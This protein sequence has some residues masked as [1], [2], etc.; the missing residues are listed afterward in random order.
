MRNKFID[1]YGKPI[2][3]TNEILNFDNF[4]FFYFAVHN[5]I[6]KLERDDEIIKLANSF[7][8]RIIKMKNEN[9]SI[10]EQLKVFDNYIFELEEIYKKYYN[11]QIGMNKIFDKK[12]R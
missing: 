7:F 2:K 8:K 5:K 11:S 9:V 4:N 1:N 3:V 6:L 10:E 12:E